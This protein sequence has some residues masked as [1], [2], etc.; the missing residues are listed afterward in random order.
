[1]RICRYRVIFI[2]AFDF[3]CCGE[4]IEYEK[5]KQNNNK[6]KLRH[7]LCARVACMQM[8][9]TSF[10]VVVLWLTQLKI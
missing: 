10:V 7:I 3:N 4:P 6:L 2:L 9:P 1:M 5:T 8:P